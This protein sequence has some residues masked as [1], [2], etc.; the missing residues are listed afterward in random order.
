MKGMNKIKATA[1]AAALTVAAGAPIAI[2]QTQGGSEG[3]WHRR[4][5][6][7]GGRGGMKGEFFGNLDLTDAQKAQLKQV[8]ETHRQAIEPLA[9]QIRTKRQEL[10]QLGDGA[11]F[12]EAAAQAK[13]TEIAALE[14]KLMGERFRVRQEMLN[15]LTPE[16]KAQL[17]QRKAEFKQKRAEGKRGWGRGRGA[18]QPNR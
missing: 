15:V 11:T 16:Q 13:L 18:E 10:R 17:E 12:D 1:L 2:A 7:F 5:G 8:R 3:G 9:Q 4:H 14:A 6:G